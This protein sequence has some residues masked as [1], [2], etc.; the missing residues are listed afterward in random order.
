MHSRLTGI[1]PKDKYRRKA[2]QSY[3]I[4]SNQHGTDTNSAPFL[5]SL[6]S[7]SLTHITCYL[8]PVSLLAL[9]RVNKQLYEHL[10]DDNVWHRAFTCQFLGIEPES[11]LNDTNYLTLRRSEP[12]WKREF[13]TKSYLRRSVSCMM[14][15][16]TVPVRDTHE[17]IFTSQPMGVFPQ[18]DHHSC[19]ASFDHL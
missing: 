12:S 10:K 14:S 16:M 18:R 5:L 8:D 15:R 1:S 2:S 17:C 6:P 11:D 9:C 4:H 3:H 19:P 13:I 7:E